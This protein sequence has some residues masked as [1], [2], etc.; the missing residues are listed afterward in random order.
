VSAWIRGAG[1]CPEDA[2][3]GRSRELAAMGEKKGRRGKL[4]QGGPTMDSE[5]RAAEGVH[6]RG[7][8]FPALEESLHVSRVG[9]HARRGEGEAGARVHG[10]EEQGAMEGAYAGASSPKRPLATGREEQGAAGDTPAPWTP[11]RSF[12]AE[13]EGRPTAGAS[14]AMGEGAALPAAAVRKKETGKKE[15]SG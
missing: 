13:E 12:S 8:G 2:R 7:L 9:G 5:G 10:A 4:L 15:G 6:G 3:H 1:A 14:S 11:G